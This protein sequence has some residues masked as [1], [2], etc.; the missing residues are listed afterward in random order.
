MA[1]RKVE[2]RP[3]GFY[4]VRYNS[5]GRRWVVAEWHSFGRAWSW[6]GTAFLGGDSDLAEIGPRIEPPKPKRKG[7]RDG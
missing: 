2:K 5:G 7:A 6:L 1:K 3:S 4:W